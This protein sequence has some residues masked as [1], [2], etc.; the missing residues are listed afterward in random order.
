[1]RSDAD[2]HGR[3]E[4]GRSFA[5]YTRRRGQRSR[6][7]VSTDKSYGRSDTI[8]IGEDE[9]IASPN[10]R[11]NLGILLKL[12]AISRHAMLHLYTS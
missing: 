12:A 8:V 1:M 11:L 10:F 5:K 9:V 4:P 3:G 2:Q 7:P 6:D